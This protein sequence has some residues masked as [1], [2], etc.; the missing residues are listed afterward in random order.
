MARAIYKTGSQCILPSSNDND[1]CYYFDTNEE[2]VQALERNHNHDIDI[3][4]VLWSNRLRIFLGCYIYPFMEY[5]EGE[6]I[7]EFATFNICEHKQEY[8]EIA[9]KH[10]SYIK[11]E[12]KNWYHILIACYM[13]ERNKNSITKAQKEKAQ[14]V[15]DEGITK[16]LKDY[17]LKQLDLIQ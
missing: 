1:Y 16:E 14:T 8:K 11:D 13:F 6:E 5:V 17:C 9:L 7:Q 12:D 15:H 3:H 2:R 10:I 4:F